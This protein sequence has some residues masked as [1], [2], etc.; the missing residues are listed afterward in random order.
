MLL[1]VTTYHALADDRGHLHPRRK[2][3]PARTRTLTLGLLIA[4][5]A[6]MGTGSAASQDA[7]P[8]PEARFRTDAP[9][10][11]RR[12]ELF[13]QT[14]QG[15][16]VGEVVDL[17][18]GKRL[19]KGS[20]EFRRCEGHSR[21]QMDLYEGDRYTGTVTVFNPQYSFTLIRESEARPWVVK[22]LTRRSSDSPPPPGDPPVGLTFGNPI[23]SL[24]RGLESGELKVV[25]VKSV[26][27]HDQEY[28]RVAFSYSPKKSKGSFLR[29]GWLDLDP[30]HDWVI[31]KGETSWNPVQGNKVKQLFAM[32]YV[33]G[34]DHHPIPK[35]LVTTTTGRNENGPIGN[36]NRATFALY[37]AKS[38]PD[39]HFTLTAFG[40]PEPPWYNPPPQRR[41]YLW[42]GAAGI[43]CLLLGF[44]LRR[45]TRKGSAA[46]HGKV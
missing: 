19:V 46:A 13:W 9:L 7:Q 39:S 31:I 32:T 3:T 23:K 30:T 44:A 43:G 5:A 26:S 16:S 34:S 25:S 8:S 21:R 36:E 11:W 40:L 6:Y 1:L 42:V 4:T 18:T 38:V 12:Y 15:S 27:E 33:D 45:A 29:E 20:S 37:E 24:P 17:V 41:W 22:D 28:V 10:G 35:E 2:A 14:L